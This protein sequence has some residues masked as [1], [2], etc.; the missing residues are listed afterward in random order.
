MTLISGSAL[1]VVSTTETLLFWENQK[2]RL[3]S[4]VSLVV[5]FSEPNNIGPEYLVSQKYHF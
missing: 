1:E 3:G 2:P 4:L 5:T